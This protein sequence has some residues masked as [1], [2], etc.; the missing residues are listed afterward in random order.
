MSMLRSLSILFVMTKLLSS[1]YA[2]AQT[3][4]TE[5]TTTGAALSANTDEPQHFDSGFDHIAINRTE[6]MEHTCLKIR[7]FIFHTDDDQVP[8][9]VRE[10]TCM[11]AARVHARQADDP[12]QQPERPIVSK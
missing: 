9:L 5:P 1:P 12:A 6:G 8:R 11:P 7:A 10:T 2:F 3:V 4:P